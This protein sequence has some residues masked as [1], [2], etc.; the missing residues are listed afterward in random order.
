MP[1]DETLSLIIIT[2]VKDNST[3]NLTLEST[4]STSS[5][6][7][8]PRN[9]YDND[10]TKIIGAT[11]LEV[12]KI[13]DKNKYV[14]GENVHWSIVIHNTGKADALNLKAQDIL[15]AGFEYI[16]FK[17]TAGVFDPEIGIWSIEGVAAGKNVILDIYSKVLSAGE[18][19][20]FVNITTDT[21]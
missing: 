6:D 2:K 11:D 8:N 12:L 20:N 9:D 4:I 13:A 3:G 15:P 10:T 18:F 5:N 17:A 7:N 19:T 16:G 1:Y 21:P 14:V